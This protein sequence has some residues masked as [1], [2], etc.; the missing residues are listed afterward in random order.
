MKEKKKNDIK[1]KSLKTIFSVYFL[2]ILLI[3]SFYSCSSG[4]SNRLEVRIEIKNPTAIDFDKYEHIVYKDL[5]LDWP[6]EDFNPDESLKT[7]FVDEL[8]KIIDKDIQYRNEGNSDGENSADN[9]LFITGKFS[10]EVKERKKIKEVEDEKGTKKNVFVAIQHWEMIM[11]LK[12]KD[13][14]TGD[15]IFQE[16]FTEKLNDVDTSESSTKFNFE[17]LFFKMTNRLLFKIK[18]TKKLQRR[19]LLL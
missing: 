10:L 13:N 8:G 14:T 15:Y 17:N 18:K 5:E 3:T 6:A 4:G 7:F 2:G 19:F 11:D 9:T 1:H 12:M 16:K